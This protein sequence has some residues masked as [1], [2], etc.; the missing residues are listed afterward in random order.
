M[1]LFMA[2]SIG[3][4]ASFVL[5]MCVGLWLRTAISL[6]RNAGTFF[7]PEFAGIVTLMT[8]CYV[9]VHRS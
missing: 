6:P 2:L 4:F 9:L 7:E 3:F 8:I 5:M 1:K